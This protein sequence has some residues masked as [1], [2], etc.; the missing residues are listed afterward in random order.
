MTKIS[1]NARNVKQCPFCLELIDAAA[2]RCP[3][4]RENLFIPRKRVRRPWWLGNFM[5]GCYFAS[6]VWAILILLYIFNFK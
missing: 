2:R 1:A 4:C 6:F 5:L 3:H